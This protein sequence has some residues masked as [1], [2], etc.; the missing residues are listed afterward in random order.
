[1][2][3]MQELF[4]VFSGASSR[5]MS[6]KLIRI[7]KLKQFATQRKLEGPVALGKVIGKKTNQTHDLLTGKA[8]FGEKVAR[9]IEEYAGLPTYWLDHLG[10]ESNTVAE[11]ATYGLV[12]LISDIQAGMY[13]DH[14]N[15][16]KQSDHSQ[17][18]IS[19]SVPIQ[20]RT[21][22]MRVVGDSMEP[23]F[24]EG[25]ILIVEPDFEPASGDFVIAKHSDTE[26]T[27]KQLIKDGADWYLKPLNNRYPL[28]PMGA[29]TI[30]GVVRAVEKR[31]R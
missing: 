8:S 7:T 10:E 18:M 6:L 11:L 12:P 19:T 29:S 21:F 25:M 26:T 3:K 15:N 5:T 31:F 9:S 13:Q 4:N 17:E 14:V 1:M 30:V 20:L 24:R 2:N 27:F 16:S 22:A 23:D 28:K